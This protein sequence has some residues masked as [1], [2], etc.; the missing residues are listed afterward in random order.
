[1]IEV[2]LLPIRVN[3]CPAMQ[4]TEGWQIKL[5]LVCDIIIVEVD[6][7]LPRILFIIMLYYR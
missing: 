3:P 7:L 6:T 5:I 2:L 4:T 1:M